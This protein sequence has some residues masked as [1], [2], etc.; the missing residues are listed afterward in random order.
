MHINTKHI[1]IAQVSI[2]ASCIPLPNPHCS[3]STGKAR[4]ELVQL[5]QRGC[6][7]IYLRGSHLATTDD[8]LI[9]LTNT[10]LR[11]H[12]YFLSRLTV[13]L[14]SSISLIFSLAGLRYGKEG[15]HWD[16]LLLQMDRVA[17][18]DGLGW[19]GWDGR[20]VVY[21]PSLSELARKESRRQ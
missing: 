10:M 8:A 4:L 19:S 20:I 9:Y 6:L 1:S 11:A 13:S 2:R 21:L 18:M 5:F 15:C 7:T 16:K 12:F 3:G 14:V 17:R